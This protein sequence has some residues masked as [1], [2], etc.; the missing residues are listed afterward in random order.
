MG[1]RDR[2]DGLGGTLPRELSLYVA[3]GGDFD[4]VGSGFQVEVG[5]DYYVASVFDLDAQQI[6]FYVQ[7]LT[8]DGPLQ[9]STATHNRTALNSISTFVI[10]GS[11]GGFDFGLD[12]LIDEVRLSNTALSSSE[13]LINTVHCRPPCGYLAPR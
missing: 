7:D 12:G 5:R 10:G 13:L 9:S 11:P 3:Q 6:T 4:F 2:D 1:S 8:N